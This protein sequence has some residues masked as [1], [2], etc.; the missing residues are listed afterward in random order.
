MSIDFSKDK[1]NVTSALIV[2]KDEDEFDTPSLIANPATKG[3]MGPL[4]P[5]RTKSK[6]MICINFNS[7]DESKSKVTTSNVQNNPSDIN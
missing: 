6:Q 2:N 3:K 5:N 7:K 4:I 1:N